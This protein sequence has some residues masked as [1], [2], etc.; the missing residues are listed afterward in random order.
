MS[1]SFRIERLR[2]PE[3]EVCALVRGG[4][5]LRERSPAPFVP[6]LTSNV[7]RFAPGVLLKVCHVQ[8]TPRNQ[9][10]RCVGLSRA[11][12]ESASNRRLS[13]MGLRCPRIT[14]VASV[15]NPFSGIDSALLVEEVPE[16]RCGIPFLNDDSVPLS[17]RL[18]FVDRVTEDLAVMLAEGFALRDFRLNNIMVSGSDPEPVWIDNELKRG[19]SR[20][21]ASAK[22]RTTAERVLRRD[23]TRIPGPLAQHLERALGTLLAGGSRGIG[24]AHV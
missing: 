22:L 19:I 12:V 8:S 24:V 6:G 9:L 15:L 3:G 13:A 21:A 16:G 20:R 2:F 1:D 10:L 5:F 14:A 7:Y 4:D 11:E 18:R 23:A 17:D